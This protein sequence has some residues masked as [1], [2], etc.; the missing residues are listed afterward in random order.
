[1]DI[2]RV[3]RAKKLKNR[4]NQTHQQW[5]EARRESVG[6]SEV[7]A[8]LGLHKY[9]TPYQLY[10]SKVGP[11][12]EKKSDA[13]TMGQ[14]FEPHIYAIWQS[15]MRDTTDGDW[16]FFECSHVL[17]HHE[18]KRLT[19]NLDGWGERVIKSD[20]KEPGADREM[21]L[22]ERYVVEIKHTGVYARGDWKQYK[23]TGNP[24]GI[25]LAYWLQVQTQLAVTGFS[26]G[27][28][29]VLIDKALEWIRI[30]ADEQVHETITT[31][32]DAFWRL[33]IERGI[34]PEVDGLDMAHIR[35]KHPTEEPGKTIER[36]D[37][38]SLVEKHRALKKERAK[39]DQAYIKPLTK[40]METVEAMI[41]CEMG[42]AAILVVGDDVE[43]VRYETR[44]RKGFTV[45]ETKK[46]VIKI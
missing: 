3:S 16:S 40:E 20:W 34:P 6:A 38:R 46:R 23:E 7:A 24:T 42:D 28:L 27:Y 2:E 37:L 5:L 11:V 12:V 22:R 9:Q 4:K 1:M 43:P 36:A 25:F 31:E 30:Q 35:A 32:V 14:M 13:I 29:V 26:H 15:K 44:T 18:C 8:L 17:Q 45:K 10:D 19:T 21:S 33:H 39:N 41:A